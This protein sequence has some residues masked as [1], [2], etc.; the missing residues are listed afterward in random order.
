MDQKR[1]N[2]KASRSRSPRR[3]SN[4]KSRSSTQKQKGDRKSNDNVG[5]ILP[6]SQDDYFK[7]NAP[8]RLWLLN[9]KD[10]YFDE[11]NSDKARR[12]FASFVRA[13]N[14]GRLRSRYYKQDSEL[15]KLSKNVVTRHN[16]GFT[17]NINQREMD[18]IK[19]SI[20][21]S[22]FGHGQGAMK[23]TSSTTILGPQEVHGR[24]QVENS[25]RH[26]DSE[27]DRLLAEER[28]EQGRRRQKQ[29]RKSAREREELILDEVAPKETGREAKIAKKRALNQ[30]RHGKGSLETEIPDDDIYES[31]TTGFEALRRER[32]RQEQRQ[33]QR[34]EYNKILRLPKLT[35]R[36]DRRAD[37]ST[38]EEATNNSDEHT[39]AT[40]EEKPTDE[41]KSSKEE[42]TDDKS[43]QT[44]SGK[45]ASDSEENSTDDEEGS[46][47][48]DEKDSDEER[49]GKGDDDNSDGGSD[50]EIETDEDGNPVTDV[51]V[52]HWNLVQPTGVSYLSNAPRRAACGAITV[53]A[54]GIAA[55]AAMF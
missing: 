43:S 49:S 47:G 18:D 50:N 15:S 55:V 41:E 31:S 7:L 3:S 16:W 12:Y 26:G 9:E 4:S 10:K 46:L 5:D 24:Q 30:I 53:G 45:D 38:E 20:H 52:S 54:I 33:Q 28:R 14:D 22:T 37:S 25:R 1:D 19:S 27:S 21:K 51:N 23:G 17:A 35:G 6:I 8:F 34:Q 11:M 2:R 39:D 32:Q 29:E 13:W 42:K 40:K 44:G 48:S 36:L